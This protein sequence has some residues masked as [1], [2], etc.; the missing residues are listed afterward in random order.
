MDPQVAWSSVVGRHQTSVPMWAQVLSQFCFSKV[1]CNA[2]SSL[3]STD[4]AESVSPSLWD[5]FCLGSQ[6]SR[7]F[8]LR[9]SFFSFFA[10]LHVASVIAKLEH[11][12][13][14]ETVLTKQQ[15]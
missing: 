5:A 7:H 8:F 14:I 6:N 11:F 13:D 12:L 3:S 9:L 4:N 10:T 15:T 2:S 1:S